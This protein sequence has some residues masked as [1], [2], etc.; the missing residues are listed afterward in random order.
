MKTLYLFSC[1]F[2]LGNILRGQNIGDLRS[3]Q[4]GDWGIAST[5]QKWNG[6]IWQAALLS[7][8]PSS[9]T[10]KRITIISPHIINYATG[11]FYA[12]DLIIEPGGVLK[13]N[14]IGA[15]GKALIIN[16]DL[17]CN[18]SL[19]NG[20]T[21]GKI[22]LAFQGINCTISGSG[23]IDCF[24][25]RAQSFTEN[26]NLDVRNNVNVRGT[27]ISVY[28]NNPN[29]LFNIHVYTGSTLNCIGSG[30][31]TTADFNLDNTLGSP[32]E[33]GGSLTVDGNL[34][35][36]GVLYASSNNAVNRCSYTINSGGNISCKGIN[37]SASGTAGTILNINEGGT[38]SLTGSDASSAFST[39]NNTYNMNGTF[40]YASS[41]AQTIR[42]FEYSCLKLSGTGTKTIETS[43]TVTIKEN[44]SL[45]LNGDASPS[46]VLGT[47][48]LVVNSVGTNLIY[49]GSNSQVTGVEWNYPFANLFINKLGSLTINSSKTFS[50][51]ITLFSGKAILGDYNLQ[52][53][54]LSGGSPSSYVI[55]NG[56]GKL[57]AYVGSS[58]VLFPIGESTN[59]YTPVTL[60]NT[61]GAADFYSVRCTTSTSGTNDSTGI[62]NKQWSVTEDNS[63]GSKLIITFQWNAI[64]EIPPFNRLD[65]SVGVK[66]GNTF[67]VT[68]SSLVTGTNPYSISITVPFVQQMTSGKV[69]C[70]GNPSALPVELG[71]FHCSIINGKVNL[72]WVTTTENCCYGFH[73]QRRKSLDD[74]NEVGFVK[75]YGSSN[76]PQTY[77]W[78]EN[79]LSGTYLYRL[80]IIDRDGNYEYSNIVT[81]DID[82]PEYFQIYQ[83]Y[84][85]P[86]NPTTN[87]KYSVPAGVHRIKLSVYSL[88]GDEI[89]ILVNE[90][91]EGGEY[92]ADFTPEFLSSGV[93][94][95]RLTSDGISLTRKMLLIK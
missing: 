16:H 10:T 78:K 25:L 24:L 38:F 65:A 46:L 48:T 44:G 71:S 66:E 36:S 52:A 84:P 45:V 39:V 28:N 35:I 61:G 7:D 40:E 47:G 73:I 72:E 81:A 67:I 4:S 54:N 12:Y 14:T 18:G 42:A 85:N 89:A 17:I 13:E 11:G 51:M 95:Y 22:T 91:K 43:K 5:W 19:G 26:I 79:V 57:K 27:G 88:L 8:I 82:A 6:T 41:G 29:H 30:V 87:I 56:S 49:S 23:V 55:E 58:S 31:T 34:I 53:E 2:L 70:I 75:A 33:Y 90:K 59:S 77:T 68:A 15:S 32:T 63:G 3:C 94:L 76:L 37:M 80:K 1:L 69:F 62:V 21:P 60:N 83:N 74:W 86:F 50:G 93:Y 9:Q 20:T 64:D 92:I